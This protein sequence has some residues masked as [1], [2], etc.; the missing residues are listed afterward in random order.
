MGVREGEREDEKDSVC[1]L[2]EQFRAEGGGGAAWG[3]C[4]L[5]SHSQATRQV[6][7]RKKGGRWSSRSR[8]RASGMCVQTCKLAPM[9]TSKSNLESKL[10]IK[11]LVF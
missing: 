1:V 2:E 5:L 9:C 3:Y 8:P 10:R 4:G 6:G 11:L 7:Y